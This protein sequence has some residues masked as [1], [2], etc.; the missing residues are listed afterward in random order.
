M[1]DVELVVMAKLGL[2][3]VK[4]KDRSPCA[5][6]AMVWNQNALNTHSQNTRGH[7]P[8]IPLPATFQCQVWLEKCTR[9]HTF[10]A[11]FN[12]ANLIAVV[13]YTQKQL[14]L[15]SSLTS[16]DLLAHKCSVGAY[17][18]VTNL[19]HILSPLFLQHHK[20]RTYLTSQQHW[21]SLLHTATSHWQLIGRRNMK[22]CAQQGATR[23]CTSTRAGETLVCN[24]FELLQVCLHLGYY[25]SA[26]CEATTLILWKLKWPD[27]SLPNAYCPITLN[28]FA[29]DLQVPNCVFWLYLVKLVPISNRRAHCHVTYTVGK[30]SIRPLQRCII[31]VYSCCFWFATSETNKNTNWPFTLWVCICSG[32]STYHSIAV[33]EQKS[34]LL[35]KRNLMIC[36]ED[37]EGIVFWKSNLVSCICILNGWAHL[38]GTYTIE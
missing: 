33:D 30:P 5:M 12:H 15:N 8:A 3:Q 7:V 32:W 29:L 1:G 26:W 20:R 23:W 6:W 21:P 17:C 38:N 24:L 10:L 4:S 18:P 22:N 9:W 37:M 16:K 11:T 27:Y 28:Q 13:Y 34:F 2:M 35:W 25:P 19:I 36:W 14:R 31:R